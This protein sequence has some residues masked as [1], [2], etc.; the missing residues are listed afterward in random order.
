MKKQLLALSLLAAFVGMA[1]AQT[2]VTIYGLMDTGLVKETGSD[3]KMGEWNS[4]RLGFRGT[5]D[6]GGGYKAT[7]Q[8]EKRFYV[9]D[10][11]INGVDWDGASNVGL[12]GSFG[13][14]RL[15]RV[16]EI[17]TESFRRLDPFN[18]EGVG[19]MLL[20]TQRTSRISNTVRYD[21]PNFSGFKVSAGYYLGGNTQ[22]SDAGREFV[23]NSA[24]NDGFAIGLNYDNGP[25]L[26]LANYARLSDS[27]SSNVWSLGGAY[28][29]GPVKI[30]LGYERTDDKGWKFGSPSGK[31]NDTIGSVRSKQDNWILSAEYVNGAH[32]VAGSFNWMK[33]RDVK[34]ST[35]AYW[36]K[37]DSGDV[38]KY[39]IGYFYSLSK[40]T[41]LY[42]Q[43]AYSDFEDKGVARFFRG[44][45]FGNDS[46]T[47]VQVGIN[48][49]F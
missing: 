46:V 34:G 3:L 6:L 1:H 26:L 39:S 33:V 48:H 2:S 10:G 31:L 20:G 21:S 42:G 9:N 37:D 28:K 17:E 11:T 40:R 49:K 18:Q 7:F 27:N 25:L 15:G 23:K 4:S 16:N 8:L 22:G 13:A 14:V 35:D 12:A 36:A 5:E 32:K 24:D 47:G 19:S 30:G 43:L 29:I 44:K 41:T 38:K 45:S